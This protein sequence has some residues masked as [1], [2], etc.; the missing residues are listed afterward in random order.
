[1]L[2]GLENLQFSL[3]IDGFALLD[4]PVDAV[5]QGM[6]NDVPFVVGSNADE[7]E[8]AIPLFVTSAEYQ[9]QV[10]D[11]FGQSGGAQIL[12]MYDPVVYGGERAA[13]SALA[14]D[15]N[16]TCPARRIA[17][18]AAA[19]SSPVYR[20][21]FTHALDS[22]IL[23]GWGAFHALELFFVFLKDGVP[24]YAFNENELALSEDMFGY[25]TR[26]AIQGDPNGASAVPWP[27]YATNS[28][29][30]IV[31]DVA[32][33]TGDGIRTAECDLIDLVGP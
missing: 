30:H 31:F 6:H 33:T 27:S 12:A 17:R 15:V 22:W 21:S 25:W 2:L 18:A 20:Y 11:Y 7:M 32:I 19:Q 3:T 26:F 10:Y 13:L 1:V 5:E 8:P 29:A 23:N 9:Q 16:F 4:A 24:T 28:D 14:T